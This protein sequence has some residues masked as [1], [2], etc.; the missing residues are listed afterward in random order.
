MNGSQERQWYRLFNI[1]GLGAKRLNLIHRALHVEG[2]GVDEL[3][4]VSLAELERLLPDIPDDIREALPTSS[5]DDAG[6]EDLEEKGIRI[7]HLGHKD[8]PALVTERLSDQCPGIL[9]CLGNLTLL[10]KP[11]VAVIGSRNASEKGLTMARRLGGE[12][13]L[14]GQNVISGFARGVDSEAHQGALQKEGTTSMVLASGILEFSQRQFEG[15]VNWD[16]DVLVISQ[17]APQERWR[18]R[19]AMKRNHL[20]CAMARAVVVIEAGKEVDSDGKMSGT[21]AAAKSALD[22]GVPL[23]VIAPSAF[24]TSPLGNAA[25]VARGAIPIEPGSAARTVVQNLELAGTPGP[26]HSQLMQAPL[27]HP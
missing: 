17:F 1:K 3:C 14:E 5:V 9:F 11:S 2:M 13:A 23:F 20:V 19:N 16:R 15:D 4:Q 27:F 21:F 25:L 6:W 7:V 22:Q 18:A 8:Y 12:L 26:V 10:N 24:E